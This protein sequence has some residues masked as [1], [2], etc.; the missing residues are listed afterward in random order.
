MPYASWCGRGVGNPLSARDAQWLGSWTRRRL[1]DGEQVMDNLG[2]LILPHGG[3]RGV[4]DLV[5]HRA[6]EKVP[7]SA[8]AKVLAYV[9]GP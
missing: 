9:S 4:S 7:R 6:D 5:Y 8:E 3:R 1:G 2:E